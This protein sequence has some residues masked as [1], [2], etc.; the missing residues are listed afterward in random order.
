M[1]TDYPTELLLKIDS[2][3]QPTRR[4]RSVALSVDRQADK[5]MRTTKRIIAS[6]L[7]LLLLHLIIEVLKV[8]RERRVREYYQR[9]KDIEL[10]KK[11]FNILTP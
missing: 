7:L 9:T 11:T 6:L 8:R 4:G 5:P 10:T 1:D 3:C 2:V